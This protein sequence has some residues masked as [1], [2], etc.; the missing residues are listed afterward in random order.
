MILSLLNNKYA[1]IALVVLIGL[2]ALWGYGARQHS[3]G[4]SQAQNERHVADLES[5]RAESKKL[6]GLSVTIESRLEELRTLEPRFIE[7]YENVISKNALPSTC[8]IDV[9]RLRAINAAIAAAGARESSESVPVDRR[10]E[11]K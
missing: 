3:L 7:R 5:F 4:Y 9:D 6:Q 11:V 2:M 10:S 1:Q 8:I